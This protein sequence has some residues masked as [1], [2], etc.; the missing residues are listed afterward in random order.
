VAALLSIVAPGPGH[1]YA[2]HTR[3]GVLWL[4]ATIGLAVI[5]PASMR[6]RASLFIVLLLMTVINAFALRLAAATSSCWCAALPHRVRPG[7]L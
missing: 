3:R 2:R 4:A 5:V 1:V 6:L 7:G